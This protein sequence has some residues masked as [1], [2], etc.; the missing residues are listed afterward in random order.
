VENAYAFQNHMVKAQIQNKDG[1]FV[2]ANTE[3]FM[4]AAGTADWSVPG[5]AADLI[6]TS[7]PNAWPIVSPTFIIVPKNPTDAARAQ[8]VL[9]FFDWAYRAGGQLARDLEY[10]PLPTAVQDQVR[11][12]WTRD[13]KGPNGQALWPVG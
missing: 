5:F 9:K 1:H 6:M 8:N 7:G 10:I 13:V 11:A 12:A 4:A 3:N 2:V